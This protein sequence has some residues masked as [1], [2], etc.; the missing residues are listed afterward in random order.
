[1]PTHLAQTCFHST[2]GPG[3]GSTGMSQTQLY[4][5]SFVDPITTPF[6][7]P[8]AFSFPGSSSRPSWMPVPSFPWMLVS[9]SGE[10]WPSQVLRVASFRDSKPGGE[11]RWAARASGGLE[12]PPVAATARSPCR[13]PFRTQVK[14]FS[15]ESKG[16]QTLQCNTVLPMSYSS[17]GT[18]CWVAAC[19]LPGSYASCGAGPISQIYQCGRQP[20]HDTSSWDGP[21]RREKSPV[22]SW[23]AG[24]DSQRLCPG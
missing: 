19:V 3:W 12:Q 11:W 14:Y 8:G 4:L 21:G 16:K 6:F 10:T 24:A 22:L 1:M 7:C 17:H 20:I 9:R 15:A 5:A 2:L 23:A 18:E 13:S